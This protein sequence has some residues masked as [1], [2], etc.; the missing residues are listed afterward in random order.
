MHTGWAPRGAEIDEDDV[1]SQLGQVDISAVGGGEPEI[2]RLFQKLKPSE[3]LFGFARDFWKLFRIQSG[4]LFK[5][6]LFVSWIAGELGSIGDQVPRLK[7]KNFLNGSL[8]LKNFLKVYWMSW[9][10]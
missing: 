2:D 6:P 10:N 8:T 1:A 4:Q 9:K 5:Q 3:F 7:G